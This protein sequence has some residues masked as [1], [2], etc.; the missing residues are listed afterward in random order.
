M[1]KDLEEYARSTAVGRVFSG[2][3][4]PDVGPSA[5]RE[6]GISGGV[7]EDARGWSKALPSSHISSPFNRR[8][9]QARGSNAWPRHSSLPPWQALGVAGVSGL[10]VKTF[11]GSCVEWASLFLI[12]TIFGLIMIWEQSDFRGAPVAR[13]ATGTADRHRRGG[14]RQSFR[15]AGGPPSLMCRWYA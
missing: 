9:L 15:S 13:R 2:C 3:P 7:G 5:R 1:G 12:G 6:R 8:K 11:D 4:G 14:S 10:E